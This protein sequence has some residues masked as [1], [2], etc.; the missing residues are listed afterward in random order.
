VGEYGELLRALGIHA[1]E[2]DVAIRYY[3]E[4][5]APHLVRF[6]SR[7]APRATDPLPEGLET[8]DAGSPLERA[9]WFQSVLKSPVIVPGVTTVQRTYGEDAGGDPA[10][11]PV[12]LYLGI[13]CSGS[14]P[15]PRRSLSFPVLAGTILVRS[16]LRAGARVMVV[17]S[18]EPGKTVSTKGF[19]RDER[20]AMTMLTSYLGTGYGFGVHRLGE[21]FGEAH[22]PDRPAHVV[23]LTDQDVFSLLD[24]DGAGGKGWDVARRALAIAG[25][26]GTMVLHMPAGW[27]DEASDKLVQDGWAVHRLY[28]WQ[29]LV[30]FA[31]AFS[32]RAYGKRHGNQT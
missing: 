29:E 10:R 14:M 25:G 4:R 32:Q 18:G 5:A 8:W 22:A 13:D 11:V 28:D 17:L 6:P 21:T 12:D 1:S 26:G 30:A 24:A 23:V 3:R 15:N 31:R 16:A 20:E 7:V 19:V 27:R 2:D 9:D